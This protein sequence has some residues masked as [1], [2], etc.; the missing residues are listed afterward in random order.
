MR[1]QSSASGATL[2]PH[3]DEAKHLPARPVRFRGTVSGRANEDGRGQQRACS[4]ACETSASAHLIPTQLE[5]RPRCEHHQRSPADRV[6]IPAILETVLDLRMRRPVRLA[7][8]AGGMHEAH[9][10]TGER[11]AER[12]SDRLTVP[13]II[14]SDPDSSETYTRAGTW[15]RDVIPFHIVLRISRTAAGA[16]QER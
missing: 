16:A 4:R 3:W 6:Y 12:A 13:W 5:R 8:L 7:F 11:R 14:S 15:C 1:A 2:L 10:R 9:A